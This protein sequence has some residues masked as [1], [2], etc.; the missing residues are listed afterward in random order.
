M[1]RLG[2]TCRETF[3]SYPWFFNWRQKFYTWYVTNM[4]VLLY[5]TWFSSTHLSITFIFQMRR[6][7]YVI[8]NSSPPDA[9]HLLLMKETALPFFSLVST[10]FSFAIDGRV[11]HSMHCDDP[12]EVPLIGR[13]YFPS[14]ELT[15]WRCTSLAT[16]RLVSRCIAPRAFELRCVVSWNVRTRKCDEA[17]CGHGLLLGK[18]QM[19]ISMW[20]STEELRDSNAP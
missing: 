19:Q 11:K 8:R 17:Y 7:Q 6:H 13:T 20:S 9:H 2:R 3:W 12:W 5:G 4:Y 14:R 10:R 15:V 16:S 18:I 1:H